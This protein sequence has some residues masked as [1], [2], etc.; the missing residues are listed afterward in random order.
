VDEKVK[1]RESEDEKVRKLESDDEK[2]IISFSL[3]FLIV[4]L[5]SRLTHLK[6]LAKTLSARGRAKKRRDGAAALP[7]HAKMMRK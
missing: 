7:N 1:K 5:L 3:R 2:V 4:M 6:A